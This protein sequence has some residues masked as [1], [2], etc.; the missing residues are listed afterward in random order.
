MN[1][2]TILG[3]ILI[4]ASEQLTF[5][6]TK[7]YNGS[8]NSLN[9]NGNVSYN[10]IEQPEKR[11]FSGPFT[12]KTANN[13]VVISGSYFN[14]L[15]SGVWKYVLTNV[16]YSDIFMKYVISA[17]VSGS[18]KD[19]NIDSSWNLSRTILMSFSNSGISEY[20]QSNLK[21]LS[22]LFDGKSVDLQKSIIATEKSIANFKNNHFFGNFSYSI[23][24]G[25][26][27][28]NGQFNEQGYFDGVWTVNYYQDG[29]LHIQ[30]RTYFNGV[31]LTIKN[32]DNST[33]EVTTIYDKTAEVN[34]FFQ[35]YEATENISRIGN[36]FYNLKEGK[37]SESNLTFLEDA[38][39]IWYNNNSLSK[40]A[41]IFEI[42]RGSNKLSAYPERKITLNIELTEK[43]R[44][45]E[46]LIAEELQKKKEAEEREIRQIQ[47]EKDRQEREK[48]RV[49]RE[50][51]YNYENSDFGKLK[52]IIKTEF[53][54][55]LVKGEFE[56]QQDYQ[57]RIKSNS[58]IIFDKIVQEQTLK[59][60]TN[61]L[62]M[63]SGTLSDYNIDKETFM[64]EFS[65]GRYY[66][67]KNSLNP[68]AI[69][70]PKNLA[71]T[72][73]Q[74]IAAEGTYIFAHI[75]DAVL[76][77]NNWVPSRL[78]IIF[79][80]DKSSDKYDI[81]ESIREEY[82]RGFNKTKVI[83]EGNGKFTL[84]F[85]QNPNLLDI[86]MKNIKTQFNE[87]MSKG[88]YFYEW[89]SSNII[90]NQFDLTLKDLEIVLPIN[91]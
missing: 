66:R 82:Y 60:K 70:I 39:S 8:F 14:D 80:F 42:E 64:V 63:L 62:E 24:A 73:K 45:E 30:I 76:I 59:S 20:Y 61:S 88:V 52:K 22:Y 57:K 74:K 23:N 87:R 21:A 56:S 72:I 77:D 83:D 25:K 86:K 48:Q 36:Q 26:S 71:Q 58:Q 90:P 32:K 41:Y 54:T 46:K 13:S 81:Y 5:G 53:S 85:M 43:V 12:F 15:K 18:F 91:E 9:F 37:T 11:I 19:G 84:V 51:I 3:L 4:I 35:N 49:E 16:S 34:E 17:N 89:V 67:N 40:S 47:L 79:P 10:Y 7:V 1:R 78:L 55:W 33:G 44:Q 29:I 65:G 6:Q 31:L 68:I 75:L 69:K 38:I 28:V 27:M 2:S 50:K